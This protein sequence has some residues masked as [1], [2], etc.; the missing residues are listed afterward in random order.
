MT[1]TQ[2]KGVQPKERRDPFNTNIIIDRTINE[3][4]TLLFILG[5]L[6][7]T[8]SYP[9]LPTN[10]LVHYVCSVLGLHDRYVRNLLGE[11]PYARPSGPQKLIGR[12]AFGGEQAVSEVRKFYR[13]EAGDKYMAARVDDEGRSLGCLPLHQQKNSDRHEC[14]GSMAL[15][16][17][18]LGMRRDGFELGRPREIFYHPKM[19]AYD[20]KEP[21]TFI[22]PDKRRYT[23]DN[24]PRVA[25]R[26]AG[27]TLI[28]PE[29]D[30]DSEGI[31][32][33]YDR[34]TGDVKASI[35]EKFDK[36]VDVLRPRNNGMPLYQ[37][38][39]GI[40]EGFVTFYT[41]GEKRAKNITEHIATKHGPQERILIMPFPEFRNLNATIPVTTKAW[42]GAYM[43]PGL[44]DFYLNTLSPV[45]VPRPPKPDPTYVSPEERWR[46]NQAR[47]EGRSI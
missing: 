3:T 36:V 32:K 19:G 12:F 11:L 37:E 7:R 22:L 45:H 10:W 47:K 8:S 28:M 2:P 23:H 6:D 18:E 1:R 5:A 41:M 31:S 27:A 34:E 15:L 9:I 17:L 14:F 35:E 39:Y 42:D 33:Q 20:P 30:L 26:K 46:R 44:P 29:H 21:Y 43:R 13:T 38:K 16:S 24:H 25:R 40:A 4:E